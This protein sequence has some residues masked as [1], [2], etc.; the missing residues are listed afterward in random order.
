MHPVSPADA[1]Y[2]ASPYLG[3]YAKS[4]V[5]CG[6]EAPAGGDIYIYRAAGGTTPRAPTIALAVDKPVRAVTILSRICFLKCAKG[7]NSYEYNARIGYGNISI[8]SK[9]DETFSGW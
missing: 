9:N 1:L 5:L 2:S 3:L 7:G 8:K 4:V 6:H